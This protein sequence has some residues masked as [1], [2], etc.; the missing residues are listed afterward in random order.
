[1]LRSVKQFCCSHLG[2]MILV[3]YLEWVRLVSTCH[4]NSTLLEYYTPPTS[5]THL[6][7]SPSFPSMAFEDTGW[8]NA[9]PGY[10]RSLL[11]SACTSFT[12]PDATDVED[13]QEVFGLLHPSG[14]YDLSGTESV[15]QASG[16]PTARPIPTQDAAGEIVTA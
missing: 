9:D 3:S 13:D 8:I 15:A 1:M 11:N 16:W 12:Y 6:Y 14:P 7:I 5:R 10:S 2:C 4:P